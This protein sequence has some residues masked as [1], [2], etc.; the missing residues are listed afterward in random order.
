MCIRDSSTKSLSALL[1]ASDGLVEQ[2]GS[3]GNQLGYDKFYELVEQASAAEDKSIAE[4]ITDFMTE[5]ASGQA[6]D[7]D[8]TLLILE[9]QK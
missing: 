3:S 4:G 6:Q 9:K 2:T 7:D 5:F 8:R 1:I